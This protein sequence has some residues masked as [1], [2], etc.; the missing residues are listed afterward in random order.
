MPSL[1]FLEAK[2]TNDVMSSTNT[3]LDNTPL[4]TCVLVQQLFFYFESNERTSLSSFAFFLSV[5]RHLQHLEWI[6]IAIYIKD[7]K[8][9]SVGHRP[10]SKQ[11]ARLNTL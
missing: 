2:S 6:V 1:F 11:I 3:T 4:Y 10:I 8:A 9:W 7:L 5:D